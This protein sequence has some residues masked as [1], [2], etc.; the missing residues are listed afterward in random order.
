V[1]KKMKKLCRCVSWGFIDKFWL[2]RTPKRNKNSANSTFS[3]I[4]FIKNSHEWRKKFLISFWP[5]H[6]LIRS[7]FIIICSTV[8]KTVQLLWL[9]RFF[10]EGFK[11]NFC[12]SVHKT[13]WKFFPFHI[14]ISRCSSSHDFFCGFVLSRFESV[15]H[16]SFGRMSKER[17][18]TC[19]N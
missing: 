13:N 8:Q 3:L 7:R 2:S 18:S 6:E 10:T 9:L 11:K 4:F 19:G 16:E 12:S 17:R 15:C 14:F 1:R 5:F